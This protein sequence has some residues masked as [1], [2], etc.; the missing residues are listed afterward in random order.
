LLTYGE[1]PETTARE[2]A[3]YVNKLVHGARPAELPIE[4]PTRFV[5]AVNLRVAKKLGVT[6][7]PQVF[8]RADQ[9]FE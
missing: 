9:V 4:E 2:A 5:L 7:P 1:N 3:A 6:I 8:L